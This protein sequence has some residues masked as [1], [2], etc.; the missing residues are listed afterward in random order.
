MSMEVIYDPALLEIV[1]CTKDPDNLFG[2]VQCNAFFEADT[3]RFNITGIEGVS[4]DIKVAN[5]VFQ[6][7]DGASG[8]SPLDLNIRAFADENG[9][10]IPAIIED[11][12]VS[13]GSDIPLG[14]VNCDTLINAIDGLFILQRDIG[15]RPGLDTCPVDT[16]PSSMYLDACDVDSDSTCGAI[17]ALFILQ[18]DIGINNVLCPE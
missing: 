11:G 1:S 7:L 3:I 10:P 17:D 6:V 4:G 18:C 16:P 13:I 14:D 2:I 9:D 15:L 12:S 5:I 8:K